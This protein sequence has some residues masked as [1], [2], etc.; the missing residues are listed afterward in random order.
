MS[1]APALPSVTWAGGKKGSASGRST[2]N[3]LLLEA[4]GRGHPPR[5]E[6]FLDSPRCCKP[7]HLDARL[8][9]TLLEAEE[10]GLH[11]WSSLPLKKHSA[12][13]LKPDAHLL[14]S[15]SVS[16]SSV[17]ELTG[18]RLIGASRWEGSCLHLQS[19]L[20]GVLKAWH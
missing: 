3:V 8:V 16:Y 2:E 6:A 13:G 17:L 9:V 14:L 19:M 20:L 11:G 1:V 18:Y 7:A 12:S 4:G 15:Q 10:I 5:A